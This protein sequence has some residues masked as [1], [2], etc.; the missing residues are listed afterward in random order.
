[1]KKITILVFITSLLFGVTAYAQPVEDKDVFAQVSF[2]PG[3][4]E[5]L[6]IS[7]IWPKATAKRR[8]PD[9]LAQ[10]GVPVAVELQGNAVAA[11]AKRYNEAFKTSDPIGK[12]SF[13]RVGGREL[14]ECDLPTHQAVDNAWKSGAGLDFSCRDIASH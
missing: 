13:A 8:R 3:S 6:K 5:S 14:L 11:F 4:P 10:S 2:G 7:I 1:M 9:S 12:F